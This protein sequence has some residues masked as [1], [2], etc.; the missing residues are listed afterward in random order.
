MSAFFFLYIHFLLPSHIYACICLAHLPH[1]H[2][3]LINIQF[4]SMHVLYELANFLF[5]E[6]NKKK[7]KRNEEKKNCRKAYRNK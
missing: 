7:K 2:K 5:P 3:Y 6:N 4:V 1:N